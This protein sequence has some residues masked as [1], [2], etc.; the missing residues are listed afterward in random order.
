MLILCV[1]I[2][3]V[4]LVT[5][6][7]LTA[8]ERGFIVL[9]EADIEQLDNSTDEASKKLM[10]LLPHTRELRQSMF[11]VRSIIGPVALMSLCGICL[12][13]HTPPLPTF[14]TATL[15]AVF[16]SILL[17]WRLA[18]IRTSAFL[19]S[20]SGL[21]T[22]MLHLTHGRDHFAKATTNT[23][24]DS[25]L[26]R[27]TSYLEK[28]ITS[29]VE[30]TARDE[31]DI[32][33]SIL[34]FGDKTVDDIMTPRVDVVTI[35]QSAS[36]KQVLET[37]LNEGYSR[38]PVTINADYNI[39]GIL[40]IKDLLSHLDEPDDYNWQLLWRRP[41]FVPESKMIDDLLHEFQKEKVHIAIVVD[42][43]GTMSGIVTMEDIIEEIVGEINDEFDETIKNPYVKVSDNVFIFD[44]RT[45]LP[46][47]YETLGVDTG[48]FEEQADDAETL[49]GLV[50]SL[51]DGFPKQHAVTTFAGL[52]FEI[53]QS[54]ARRVSK[55]KVSRTATATTDDEA[56]E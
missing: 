43:Y 15:V 21:L 52:T 4:S 14:A 13:V 47:F 22:T 18:V 1:I 11:I 42:E 3:T 34:K 30:N 2:F 55:I 53:L 45:P 39:G 38:I 5:L 25:E 23:L 16:L 33:K 6:A 31:K 27:S 24:T 17:P 8:A 29:K 7:L 46:V 50:L 9:S 54:D 12:M 48:L 49:A 28:A 36:Y 41:Y 10:S 35:A 51:F 26:A 56:E 40:Y 32:L 44:G 20:M 37:I 19:K